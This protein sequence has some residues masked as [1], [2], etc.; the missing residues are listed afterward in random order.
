MKV[1]NIFRYNKDFF[2]KFD[3]SLYFYWCDLEE[4][5]N[6]NEARKM[7]LELSSHNNRPE[8]I[9]R[10]IQLEI[11]EKQWENARKLFDSLIAQNQENI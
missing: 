2:L 4:R 8:V 11:R 1:L 7:Y 10:H 9:L 5:E 3:T 6:S